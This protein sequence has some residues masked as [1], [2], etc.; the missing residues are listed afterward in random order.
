MKV[1]LTLTLRS[2]R[3]ILPH[4]PTMTFHLWLWLAQGLGLLAGVMGGCVC[5]WW[6]LAAGV[7][8][9]TKDWDLTQSGLCHRK[10]GPLQTLSGWTVCVRVCLCLETLHVSL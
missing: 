1:D 8:R 3:L 2:H 6:L 7:G 4:N 10:D 5:R 9:G